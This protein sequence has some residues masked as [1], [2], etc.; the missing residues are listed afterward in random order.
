MG[1]S[2]LH[3]LR[4]GA[5]ALRG[6]AGFTIVAVSTLALGI[7]ANT[8]MFGVVDALL[9]KP[10]A[11]VTSPRDVMK[12]RVTV[13]ARG[14]EGN[15]VLSPV[16]SYP[17]LADLRTHARGFASFAAFARNSLSIGEGTEARS[18]PS[19]LVTGT[20]FP[21][22]GVRPALGRLIGPSDDLD[23][24]AVPVAVLSWDF[25]QR[26][27]SGDASVLGRSIRINGRAFT[28]I[29]VAPEHFGGTDLDAPALWVPMGTST[30]LGYDARM[31]RS[32]FASWL[33]I[34]GRLAPGTS[35]EQAQASAQAALLAAR[36]AGEAP[37]MPGDAMGATPGGEVRVE[38]GG[39]GRGGPGNGPRRAPPPRQVRL[40]PL[41][42]SGTSQLPS[43]FGGSQP[44][45]VSLWFLAVT[46]AVLLI[47]CANVANL[48]LA[49]A[50]RREHEIAVRPCRCGA[51]AWRLTRQLMIEVSC[52]Q[53]LAGLAGAGGVLAFGGVAAVADG[54]GMP[55]LPPFL[56]GARRRSR[57]R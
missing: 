39:P 25:W 30:M 9:F 42:G 11:G 16:L 6:A 41:G 17:D 47:A 2:L 28:I 57:P 7:G 23:N 56:D 24:A 55:P 32:R 52:W 34:V 15:T 53:R 43:P 5:R 51:P 10:P 45:P 31:M 4:Y 49:R 13:P 48:L 46:G 36:D 8:A 54:R 50:A 29:G 3:D 35:V 20:Y 40:S 38:L 22:L 27:Y 1:S 37:P 12:V 26:S 21:L 44:V 19:L 14:E 18:Q 33:S